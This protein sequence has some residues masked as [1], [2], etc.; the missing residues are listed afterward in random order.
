MQEDLHL[1]AL[2]QQRVGAITCEARD[3]GVEGAAKAAFAGG[4]DQEMRLVV[5]IAAHQSRRGLADPA[6][7]PRENLLHPLGVGSRGLGSR[8]RA[9]QLRRRDHLHRLGDLLCRLDGGDA[10]SEVL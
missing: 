8:L 6:S 10:V 1:F 7:D 9:T 5:A 2:A 4:D 3:R